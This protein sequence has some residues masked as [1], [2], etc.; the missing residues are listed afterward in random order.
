MKTRFY[1]FSLVELLLVLAIISL[2]AGIAFAAMGPAREK[3]RERVCV[4]NLHQVGQALAMYIADYDGAEATQGQPMQYAQLG[5]PALSM[6]PSFF[7]AYVKNRQALLCPDYHGRMPVDKMTTT[8]SWVPDMDEHSSD[9]YRF[10]R[11]VALRGGD[12]PL[13]TDD[14]HNPP[15]DLQKAP[16]WT[17]ERVIVLRLSQQVQV[18]QVPV[19]STYEAW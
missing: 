16:R 8:Y 5:L 7:F 19:R 11:I 12:T 2:L 14:Q 9:Y 17:L 13:L 10:S 6:A 1:A 15:F 4:S 18:K 3:S